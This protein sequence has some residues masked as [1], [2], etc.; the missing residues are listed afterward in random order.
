M[1]DT[2]N[3]QP[4]LLLGGASDD[5]LPSW[6]S[7]GDAIFFTSNRTGVPEVWRVEIT[8][9][10]PVQ[11]TR[12]GG[13]RPIADD[14]FVYYTK[15]HGGAQHGS[16]LYRKALPNGDVETV[17]EE[18][19]FHPENFD[20]V[21]G[22][23]YYSTAP[24]RTGL[25]KSIRRLDLISGEDHEIARIGES[26]GKGLSVSDGEEA[27]VYAQVDSYYSDLVLFDGI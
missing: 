18:N 9:G 17:L 24:R 19:V 10:D 1:F 25:V 4:R 6:S 20:V 8:G 27:L 14:R 12:D 11:V 13:Y 2:S 16:P 23:V 22:R 5:Y 15:R 7:S 26:P 3:L 21:A